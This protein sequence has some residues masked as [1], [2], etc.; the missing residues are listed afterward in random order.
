MDTINRDRLAMAA[1]GVQGMGKDRL[2]RMD[3]SERDQLAGCNPNA[4]G[5]IQ[6]ILAANNERLQEPVVEAPPMPT[7][8]IADE[9]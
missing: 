1:L 5:V 4:S 9:E 6:K 3:D 8:I 2:H 7:P